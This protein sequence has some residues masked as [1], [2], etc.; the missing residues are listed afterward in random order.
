MTMIPTLTKCP[1]CGS[2]KLK[3]VRS[4]FKTRIQGRPATVP[5]LE[6]QECPVC[7]EVLFDCIAMERLEALRQKKRKLARAV[8]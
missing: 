6:R 3:L 4:D 7:G 8:K 1:T 2:R 5:D